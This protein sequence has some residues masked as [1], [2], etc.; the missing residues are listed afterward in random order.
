MLKTDFPAASKSFADLGVVNVGSH[1]GYFPPLDLRPDE[2][3][4]HGPG[5]VAASAAG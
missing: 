3:R 1:S 4:V 2:E 5:D